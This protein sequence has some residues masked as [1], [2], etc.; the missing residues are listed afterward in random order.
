M[1]TTPS[2]DKSIRIRISEDD[3]ARLQQGAII[4]G[5]SVSDFIRSNALQLANTLQT[6]R[7]QGD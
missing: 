6:E 5:L 7:K 1:R 3:R 4:A 2:K